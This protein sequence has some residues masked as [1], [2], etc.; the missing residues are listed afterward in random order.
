M[1]FSYSFFS[2]RALS[3]IRSI[4]TVPTS[5]V[6]KAQGWP[7]RLRL[8]T[9]AQLR[10]CYLV[11]ESLESLHLMT[12]LLRTL[13]TSLTLIWRETFTLLRLLYPISKPARQFRQQY[14]F[15]LLKLV[16]YDFSH[17]MLF[18]SLHW[19]PLRCES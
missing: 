9:L 18:C 5:K 12:Q 2:P 6:L 15:S 16:W 10:C 11:M 14:L 19:S 3:A 17:F 1:H 8:V 4:R 7:L 13:I